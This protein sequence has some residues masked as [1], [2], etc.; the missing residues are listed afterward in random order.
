MIYSEDFVWLHFPKCAGTKIQKLFEKYFAK[1]TLIYQDP[2][3]IQK[4]SSIA[5]HDSISKREKRDPNFSLGRRDIICSFR[6]LPSWLESRYN[7]EY[8][9]SPNLP[10]CPE[11]ILEGY[12]FEANGCEN[13][14]D[15]YVR[16]YL[17]ENLLKTKNVRFIR[18]EFFESDFKLVFGD[19]LDISTIPEYEYTKKENTSQNELSEKIRIKLH[20]EKSVYLKCPY[21]SYIESIAYKTVE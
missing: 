3:G 19:Y 7:F 18:T 20:S 11:K 21:W 4:D 12:F 17:P 6:K 1:N 5:W 16:L 14:A 2:V 8:Q 9:R 10:H 15:N 13:H